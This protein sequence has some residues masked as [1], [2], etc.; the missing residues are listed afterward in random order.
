[1]IRF[2]SGYSNREFFEFIKL[3]TAGWRYILSAS[4]RREQHGEWRKRGG[5]FAV[6]YGVISRFLGFVFSLLLLGLL[7]WLVWGKE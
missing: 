4:Y 1:M 5:G 7:A 6:M 2:G 3:L